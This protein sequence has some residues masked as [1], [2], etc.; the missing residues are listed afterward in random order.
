MSKERGVNSVFCDVMRTI[1][2]LCANQLPS[3]FYV[4]SK[5]LRYI[6]MVS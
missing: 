1:R 3:T 4:K 6:L 5:G 2:Y